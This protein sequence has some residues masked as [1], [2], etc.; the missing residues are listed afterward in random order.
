MRIDIIT[1]FPKILTDPLNESIIKQARKRIDLQINLVDLR[2]YSQDRHRTVDDTPYGGGPG[3]I[4]K[5]EPLF[6]ALDTI[7]PGTDDRSAARVIFPT[8]Q[9]KLFSQQTAEELSQSDHLVFICGHYKAIDQRVI[10]SWVTDEISIGDFILSGGEIAVLLMVDAIIRL[11]PGVLS[12]IDS[13]KTDSFQN[14]LLDCPYYTR[15]EVFRGKAVPEILISG[16]HQKIDEWRL[17]QKVEKTRLRRP[18][19]YEKY[20]SENLK[21]QKKKKIRRK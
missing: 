15:P 12:D 11:R 9:G 13:A 4:L 2:D 10:D 6:N 17:N 3:M 7:F 18:D 21:Q 19:L 14:F 8:P 1:V 16:N 20:V 5:P